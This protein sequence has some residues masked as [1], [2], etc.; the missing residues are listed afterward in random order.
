MRLP[1]T[2]WANRKSERLVIDCH[3][4]WQIT[5]K[6]SSNIPGIHCRIPKPLSKL[7]TSKASIAALNV[8]WYRKQLFSLH[9]K[10]LLWLL[11]SLPGE[12]HSI[13]S[14]VSTSPINM[15][16]EPPGDVWHSMSTRWSRNSQ[17]IMNLKAFK[18]APSSR[19]SGLVNKPHK[20]HGYD[21]GCCHVIL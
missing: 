12:D 21:F 6:I 8:K 16:F 13:Y 3:F 14:V 15:Y 18:L 4:Y 20:T 11:P 1:E 17:H 2:L 7:K 19:N 10:D 5:D 9:N